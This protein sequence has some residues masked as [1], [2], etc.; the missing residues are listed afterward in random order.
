M[1]EGSTN[2]VTLRSSGTK[3]HRHKKAADPTHERMHQTHSHL[4]FFFK[5]MTKTQITSFFKPKL[6]ITYLN[7]SQ[8]DEVA[9][10]HAQL[11]NILSVH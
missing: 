3:S 9:D 1:T 8:T 4:F 5:Q 11:E 6:N 10:I 2:E 7:N